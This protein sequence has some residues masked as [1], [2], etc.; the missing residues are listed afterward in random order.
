MV[1]MFVVNTW[2]SKSPINLADLR[3]LLQFCKCHGLELELHHLPSALNLYVDRLSRRRRVVDYLP[4]LEGV[5]E[6]GWV[7][8]S[9][10]DL[11]VDWRKV[12]LLRPPLEMLPLVP[13]KAHQ[14]YFK[15]LILV[16]LAET[17]LVPGVDG[18]GTQLVRPETQSA[19]EREALESHVD[20]LLPS[21]GFTGN[22]EKMAGMRQTRAGTIAWTGSQ[23]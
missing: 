14:D 12:D 4:S 3:R 1:T 21:L 5:P 8:E 2:V 18:H 19:R 6:H 15:G 11:K 16:P 22:G 17:E 10:H 7:G 13:R 9:E 23:N 20:I